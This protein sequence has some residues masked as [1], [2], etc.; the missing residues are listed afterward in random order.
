MSGVADGLQHVIDR[1]IGLLLTLE[2]GGFALSLVFNVLDD[3][4]LM[5][6]LSPLSVYL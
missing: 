1:Q 2:A 3:P 6:R 5:M 4:S